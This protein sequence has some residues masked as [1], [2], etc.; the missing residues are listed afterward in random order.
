MQERARVRTDDAIR[1]IRT[2]VVRAR[3]AKNSPVEGVAGP[4]GRLA[5]QEPDRPKTRVR[6]RARR[7]RRRGLSLLALPLCTRPR[8]R[9]LHIYI[10]IA[11]SLPRSNLASFPCG[12]VRQSRLS[13]R[14]ALRSQPASLRSHLHL[15]LPPAS[16]ARIIS[17]SDTPCG[18]SCDAARHP[19]SATRRRRR[20]RP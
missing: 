18:R 15:H 6:L 3:R 17:T 11:T 5:R 7:R 20:R 9:T 8:P 12:P 19:L 16:G 2:T 4:K 10:Y 14:V 13:R 1:Q